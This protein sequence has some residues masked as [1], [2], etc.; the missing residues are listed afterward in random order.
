M[1]LGV[2]QDDASPRFGHPAGDPLPHIDSRI[3]GGHTTIFLA[4]GAPQVGDL[5]PSAVVVHH[6]HPALVMRHERDDG[7]A[8]PVADVGHAG[9][10]SKLLT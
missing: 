9:G 5:Q 2:T 3:L 8:D 4:V 6:Q 10:S 1:V 7:F